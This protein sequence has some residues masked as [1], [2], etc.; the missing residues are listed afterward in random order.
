[1]ILLRDGPLEK[2]WGGWGKN[3]KKSMQTKR[4]WKKIH[5]SDLFKMREDIFLKKHTSTADNLEKKC[6]HKK[7]TPPPPSPH[8]FSNGPSLKARLYQR[9]SCWDFWWE[10][11]L[12]MDVNEWMSSDKG[13]YTWNIHNLEVAAKVCKCKLALII[14][15]QF[16]SMSRICNEK[17]SKPKIFLAFLS[18]LLCFSFIL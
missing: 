3:R 15:R 10:F 5:A 6:K 14:K 9:S 18:K 8:H 13:T 11:R 16:F 2:W 17:C 4:V 12:L 7:F 1:M